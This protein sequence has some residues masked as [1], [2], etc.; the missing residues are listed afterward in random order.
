GPL[1]P[2]R[3]WAIARKEWIQIKRDTRSMI[4]AFALPL[5]LLLFF[6]YAIT[7]D[8]DDIRIAVLDQDRT[9]DSRELVEAFEASGYFTVTEHLESSSAVAARLV[10]HSDLGVLAI[11]PGYATDLAAPGRVAEVQLL[12]DGSDAN[13]ATIAFNY[14]DAIVSRHA[15]RVVLS[16]RPASPPLVL[17]SRVWYNPN[18]ES[19]HM[20]V[21]G[22]V[23]V[24]MSI[25]AAMLTAL[26][27]AREWERGTMEQLAATPVSRL[28]VVLGKLL[29]YL[30]IGLF[31]VAVTVAAGMLI[32]G[33]PFNG[34][35]L[36][37]A[38]LT[39]LF[40]LGALGLGMFISAA[41]KSQVLATQIAMV[42]TYLPAVLLSGFIFDIASMP[43]VLRGVTF[44][45]PARY[46]VTVTR[47]IFLKGVG[48]TVL[49]PQAT[50][51][52]LYALL[53]LGLATRAF[54]KELQA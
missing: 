21:P 19:R 1:D 35:V 15:A 47:G 34:S 49:L 22:L 26:T 23:A 53:G 9:R 3:F 24:I 27:I 38:V 8:V 43:A 44:L 7:W 18:L 37:L 13:T 12:L 5:F 50:L 10:G 28:E 2:V 4:L 40:L 41:I 6:G 29:P 54:R 14:A 17:E 16:G 48:A 45:I 30:A 20:I 31:D 36:L 51:M 32:F 25:I 39:L 52:L 11:A 33:T 42:A 46:F